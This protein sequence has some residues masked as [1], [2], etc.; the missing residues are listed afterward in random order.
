MRLLYVVRRKNRPHYV[1]WKTPC[2]F[3]S[4]LD[5]S[6]GQSGCNDEEV[7]ISQRQ[8][9]NEFCFYKSTLPKYVQAVMLVWILCLDMLHVLYTTNTKEWKTSWKTSSCSCTQEIPGNS[10]KP[11]VRYRFCENPLQVLSWKHINPF[12][13][14]LSPRFKTLFYNLRYEGLCFP[15]VLFPSAFLITLHRPKHFSLL[16]AC[17]MLKHV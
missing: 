14:F 12:H 3:G 4:G 13:N 15:C 5:R 9:S 10:S 1:R 8:K 16:Y 7:D 11:K 17:Y 6:Q 2:P